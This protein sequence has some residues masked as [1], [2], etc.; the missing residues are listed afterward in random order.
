M[1]PLLDI[2]AVRSFLGMISYDN[3]L[4]PALSILRN[5]LNKLLIEHTK[6]AWTEEFNRASH[7]FK[8]PLTSDLLLCN[9]DPRLPISTAANISNYGLGAIISH[10][11]PN[12]TAKPIAHVSCTLAPAEN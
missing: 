9:F 8:D 6:R 5:P 7:K 11:W 2:A 3:V 4:V 10:I 1:P 12:G